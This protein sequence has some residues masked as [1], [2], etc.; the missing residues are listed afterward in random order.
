MKDLTLNMTTKNLDQQEYEEQFSNVMI[1]STSSKCSVSHESLNHIEVN[2][3]DQIC[4][5]ANDYTI[6]G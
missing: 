5:K 2:V 6:D 3:T 1:V 4:S